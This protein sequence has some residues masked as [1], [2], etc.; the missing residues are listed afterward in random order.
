M[1]GGGSQGSKA[2]YLNSTYVLACDGAQG[3]PGT[4]PVQ[5]YGLIDTPPEVQE[6][7]AVKKPRQAKLCVYTVV[8]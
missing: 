2:E 3:Q 6:R 7:A 8:P 5:M 1:L 4:D